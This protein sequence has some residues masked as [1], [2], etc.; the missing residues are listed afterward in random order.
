MSATLQ[1]FYDVASP[2]S[3]LA[4][5]RI[6]DVCKRQEVSFDYRP[7]LLGGVFRATNNQT[8]AA[9][10]ARAR[11]LLKDL[12]RWATADDIDF[13]FSSSFPHNSLLAMRTITAVPEVDRCRVAMKIFEAAW[14]RDLDIGTPEVL[15]TIL[16]DDVGFLHRSSEQAVKDELR[17]TTDEA[18]AAGAFGAPFF[19]IGDEGY[20]GN[21]RL[22]MAVAYAA[23]VG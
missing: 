17:R 18:I 5:T 4:F 15:A 16:G 14:V 1:F 19:L 9:I 8:P 11:Y 10:P 20:W 3:Y 7:F 21:D 2:Y 13:K 22:E 23:S 6:Q 12:Q